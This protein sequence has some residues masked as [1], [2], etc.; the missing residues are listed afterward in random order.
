VTKQPVSGAILFLIPR[1]FLKFDEFVAFFSD[2][3]Y[4][5]PGQVQVFRLPATKRPLYAY[6]LSKVMLELSN[7]SSLCSKIEYEC[8]FIPAHFQCNF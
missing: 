3:P 8:L 7:L 1:K 5:K 6:L 4:C 2:A